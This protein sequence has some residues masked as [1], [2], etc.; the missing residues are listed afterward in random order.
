VDTARHFLPL[1]TLKRAL[2]AMAASKLN[3]F[4]W[5]STQQSLKPIRD[6]SASH[7]FPLP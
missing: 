2:D 3:V 4:M 5:V 6:A 7:V 1:P